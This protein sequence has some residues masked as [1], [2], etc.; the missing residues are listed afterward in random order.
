MLAA[1]TGIAQVVLAVMYIFTARAAGPAEYGL[2]IAAVAAGTALVGYTDFG[3]NS[4]WVRELANSG[5]DIQTASSRARGKLIIAVI[6]SA[7]IIAASFAF[8]LPSYWIAGPILLT[9][10]VRQTSVV[11]LRA[12]ALSGRVALVALIERS[13]GFLILVALS[14]VGMEP[15][16]SLW[17]ALSAGS[18]AAAICAR[19]LTPRP[20]RFKIDPGLS[21]ASPYSGARHYGL[22]SVGVSSQSLDLALLTSVAGAPAAGLYGAVN[23]WTQPMG[24][25]AN[26]F[27]TAAI[28]F[29]AKSPDVRVALR[30]ISRGLWLLGLAVGACVVALIGSPWIVPL[31]VGKEYEGAIQILQLLAIGTI[32]A[33]INQPIAAFLQ[34]VGKDRIV[35]YI[36]VGSVAMQLVLILTLGTIVGAVGAGIALVIVQFTLLALLSV[37]VVREV[38]KTITPIRQDVPDEV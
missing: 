19:Q 35:S 32:P 21:P 4:L 12:S 28:P 7:L 36:V 26:A 20:L 3:T 6:G 27:S 16:A 14:S 13:A 31:L 24:L 17:I 23:R 38:T 8:S 22:Y 33:I 10:L 30:A 34:A 5:I 29:V 1:A 15:T 9:Q 11:P 37:V 2:T 25:L 18:I